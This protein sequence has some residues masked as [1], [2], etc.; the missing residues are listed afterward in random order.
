M[1]RKESAPVINTAKVVATIS[2]HNYQYISPLGKGGQATVHLVLSRQYNEE[3]VVKIQRLTERMSPEGDAEIRTLMGLNHPN[4]IRM[5]DYFVDDEYLYTVLEYCSDGSLGDLIKKQ[6]ALPDNL[7]IRYATEMLKALEHCH[8]RNIAH[9][10]LKPDNILID[11]YGRAKLADFGISVFMEH[12][13]R[14]RSFSG[15][16]AFMAPEIFN[17]EH[18]SPFKADIFAA[19]VVMYMMAVGTLPWCLE[20]YPAM[21]TDLRNGISLFPPHM[22]GSQMA[23]LIS[24]MGSA[25]EDQRPSVKACLEHRAL[26]NMAKPVVHVVKRRMEVMK[27][28]STATSTTG[29]AF[30]PL[31]TASQSRMKKAE[32]NDGED[33]SKSSTVKHQNFMFSR[34]AMYLARSSLSLVPKATFNCMDA[35]ERIDEE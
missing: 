16:K 35:H 20:S 22:V 1:Q 19:G 8:A 3:F 15:S 7:T 27:A 9:R 10:D 21:L 6:G 14:L 11:K 31:I 2:E 28:K 26:G 30:R 18:H 5:F 34:K 24:V 25:A 33:W 23:R 12:G 29:P 13:E 32:S 17:G 4:I